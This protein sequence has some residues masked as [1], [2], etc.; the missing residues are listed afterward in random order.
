MY[1][2]S[3]ELECFAKAII[4]HFEEFDHLA[5]DVDI[6]Y[7]MYEGEP[8]TIRGRQVAAF[9]TAPDAQGQNKKIYPWVL[10]HMFGFQPDVIMVA[11]TEQWEAFSDTQKIALVYHELC[12]IV[13]KETKAGAPSFDAE[14]KPSLQLVDHDIGEFNAV[15]AKFGAWEPGLEYTKLLL[16]SKSAFDAESILKMVRESMNEVPGA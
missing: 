15:I 11:D 8:I 9:V 6:A 2:I 7:L 14:G 16:D 12:H 3:R 4:Q 5:D 1:L 13:Q 10:T